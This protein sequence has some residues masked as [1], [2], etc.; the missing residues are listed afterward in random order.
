ML[1][2][3]VALAQHLWLVLS[4]IAAFLMAC[5]PPRVQ[6]YTEEGSVTI[7]FIS[8]PTAQGKEVGKRQTFFSKAAPWLLGI[9]FALQLLA[10]WF[11]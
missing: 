5:Y 4:T 6:Q 3:L 11:S 8:Q 9:G 10:A 2:E 1:N 7:N